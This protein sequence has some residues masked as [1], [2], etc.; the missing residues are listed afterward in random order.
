VNKNMYCKTF[1]RIYDA[2]VGGDVTVCQIS[3]D[4]S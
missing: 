2:K 3:F 4:Q 1:F